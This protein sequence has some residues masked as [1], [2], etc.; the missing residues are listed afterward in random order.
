MTDPGKGIRVRITTEMLKGSSF[1]ESLE[2]I[3]SL[4][5]RQHVAIEGEGVG[6]WDMGDDV[7]SGVDDQVMAWAVQTAGHRYPDRHL[8]SA[9][10]LPQESPPGVAEGTV[11]GIRPHRPMTPEQD[12]RARR[13]AELWEQGY[14]GGPI[15]G[16]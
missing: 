12:A 14:E 13:Y 7:P 6:I 3:A 11:D 2:W 15:D 1:G 8:R 16:A 9:G 5:I 4:L 10:L